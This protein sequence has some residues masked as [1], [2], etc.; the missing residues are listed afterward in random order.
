MWT[1]E[2]QLIYLKWNR[3]EYIQIWLLE[4]PANPKNVSY[5]V[6]TWCVKHWVA[7]IVR[8]LT[9]V[10]NLKHKICQISMIKYYIFGN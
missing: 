8:L 2:T 4:T 5:S 1:L 6:G 10:F 9:I 7:L 3:E